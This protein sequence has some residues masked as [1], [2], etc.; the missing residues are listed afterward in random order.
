MIPPIALILTLSNNSKYMTR[1]KILLFAVTILILAASISS[2]VFFENDF[3]IRK[4]GIP[5]S[6]GGFLD[7]RQMAMAAESYSQGYDPLVDNPVNPTG[8][9]LN[10]PRI[11]HL[12]FAFGIN[13][14]HTNLIGSITVIIFFIGIGVFWFSRKF[15]NLTYCVLTIAA[16]S[17]AAMLGVER[18]NIELVLFFILSL[19]LTINYY[20]SV[21]ALYVFIFASILKLYPVFGFVYLLKENKRKFWILFLPALGIFILYVV[22]SLNDFMQVYHTTPKSVGSSFGINVW[23]MGLRHGRFFNL[24]LSDSFVLRLKVLS[25]TV[26]FLIFAVT[27]LIGIRRKDNKLLSEAQYIDA[28]RVGAAIYIGCFLLMNT[29]DYRLIFLFFTIP[30][31]VAWLRDEEKG[32]SLVSKITLAA[33]IFSLW[34]FFVMHFLGRKLT[35]AMEEFA[36]W[37]MLAGLLYLFFCSLPAWF[38]KDLRRPFSSTRLSCD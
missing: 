12:L 7:A 13:Q 36:N 33:M 2:F 4:W 38:Q 18:A 23:W 17:P 16:L 31:I 5:M 15:D 24:P 27:L 6:T 14:S 26:A 30:Q 20:S 8:Q 1:I 10:Y 9:R 37:I 25:Y 35:F 22:L 34:S 11:W 3:L 29:H 21:S 19:A 32:I 28:F